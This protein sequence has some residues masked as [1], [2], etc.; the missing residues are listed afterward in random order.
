ML[1]L[2]CSGLF[3][4]PEQAEVPFGYVLSPLLNP[5]PS[6]PRHAVRHSLSQLSAV[7]VK[8]ESPDRWPALLA[9]LDESTKSASAEDRRVR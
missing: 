2:D 8:R 3:A 9:L 5:L 4:R 1:P 7:L 6:C